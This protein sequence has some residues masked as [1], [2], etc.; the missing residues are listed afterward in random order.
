MNIRRLIS[1]VLLA[2]TLLAGSQAALAQ[3]LQFYQKPS[4]ASAPIAGSTV[5]RLT[6]NPDGSTSD[7][8]ITRTSGSANIDNAAVSWMQSQIMRPVMLNGKGETFSIV[9]EI[10][11]SNT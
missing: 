7:V 5:M 11:Y 2:A 9:K 1:S 6:I 4:Q 10:K 8:R 3:S